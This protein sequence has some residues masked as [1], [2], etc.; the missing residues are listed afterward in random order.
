MEYRERVKSLTLKEMI[1][2]SAGRQA[3]RLEAVIIDPSSK[4]VMD[5][6][7]ADADFCGT[8]NLPRQ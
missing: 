6:V 5:A 7:D 1:S 4:N 8:A 2:P 3:L